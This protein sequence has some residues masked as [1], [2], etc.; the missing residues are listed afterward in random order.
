MILPIILVGSYILWDRY[1]R[2]PIN[3]EVH[4]L[5]Q[6]GSLNSESPAHRKKDGQKSCWPIA[7][8]VLALLPFWKR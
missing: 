3:S 7:S 2:L 5:A 1:L 6:L 8:P 4:K